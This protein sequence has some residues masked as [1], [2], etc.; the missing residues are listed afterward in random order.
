MKLNEL[1]KLD[2]LKVRVDT[3]WEDEYHA[4]EDDL[5]QVSLLFDTALFT[6]LK[7]EE[8]ATAKARGTI[9][10]ES[11]D[12]D[13]VIDTITKYL[14][15]AKIR[16]ETLKT[17]SPPI[18]I[19]NANRIT[20]RLNDYTKNVHGFYNSVFSDTKLAQELDGFGEKRSIRSKCNE[21]FNIIKELKELLKTKC[22]TAD[23]IEI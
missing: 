4:I 7:D 9:L 21:Y 19:D 15:N 14:S 10:K 16:L 22:P 5:F 1:L 17:L 11:K 23:E 12:Y 20:N 3:T 2:G 6:V 8:N 13:K 18:R